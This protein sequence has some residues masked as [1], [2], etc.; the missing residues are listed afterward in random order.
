MIAQDFRNLS[1][2]EVA[3]R[4]EALEREFYTLQE[5]VRIG[6]EKN[7]ARLGFL[8]KDIARAKTVLSELKASV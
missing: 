5:S 2:E 7:H 1:S 4:L 3:A 6:K 8:K